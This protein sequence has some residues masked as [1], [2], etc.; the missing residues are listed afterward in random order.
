LGRSLISHTGRQMAQPQPVD[1]AA[2]RSEGRCA[3]G[4]R[5]L[6]QGLRESPCL[7]V[8]G[9]VI[10]HI[11]V[12]QSARPGKIATVAAAISGIAY[13]E[14]TAGRS[15][16][17]CD[18]NRTPEGTATPHRSADPRIGRVVRL[19][20]APPGKSESRLN[21]PP[22]QPLCPRLWE[23]LTVRERAFHGSC[24]RPR[25]TA[26][27]DDRGGRTGVRSWQI[28]RDVPVGGQ[29]WVTGIRSP[30]IGEGATEGPPPGR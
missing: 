5:Q 14:S 11:V 25:M 10:L 27:R 8:L 28:G 7:A 30:A 24:T 9:E 4:G 20:V 19:F 29:R 22:C 2:W 15:L 23:V 12:A 21:G 3:N 16:T 17:G 6:L 1:L 18:G 26:R 13:Q